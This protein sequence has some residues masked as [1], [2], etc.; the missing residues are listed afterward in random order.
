MLANLRLYCKYREN[1]CNQ[2]LLLDGYDNHLKTC[3]FN[4]KICSVCECEESDEHNCIASLLRMNKLLKEDV[5]SSLH[6]NQLLMQKLQESKNEREDLLQTIQNLSRNSPI[7]KSKN[8]SKVCLIHWVLQIT[9]ATAFRLSDDSWIATT[10]QQSCDLSEKDMPSDDRPHRWNR[11]QRFEQW[12][13][14]GRSV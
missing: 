7:L 4:K 2:I 10:C 12:T 5:D 6:K 8:F 13:E 14:F 3:S 9:F 1:G 11:D